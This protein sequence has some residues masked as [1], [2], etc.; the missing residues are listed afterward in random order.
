MVA[1]ALATSIAVL[2]TA[3]GATAAPVAV[4]LYAGSGTVTFPGSTTPVTVW[5]YTTTGAAP[6]APGGP[7][8]T[9]D[10]GDVVTITL[11]NAL[12][13][14]TSLL[15]Q[16][17]G[18]APD[19][20]G[21]AAA[22]TKAYTFTA[23][24]P[25][26]YLYEAGLVP[27]AQYQVAMGLY[28]ALVVRPTTAGQ[29]YDDAATAFDQEQVLVL[30]E[31]D[32]ALN[33]SA[34]RATY[35]LRKYSPRYFLVNG[36]AYPDTTSIPTTAGGKLLLRYVNAGLQYHSM[37]LQGAY[38]TV[39]ALDGSPLDLPRRYA[40]DTF[41]PG[42]TTD[43]LVT[44]STAAPDRRLVLHD[45]SM[46]LHNSNAAGLGGML[47]F[48][49]VAGTGTTGDTA[50]PVASSVALADGTLTATISDAS[51]GGS[52]VTGATAW[53]DSLVGA[54]TPMTAGDAGFDS[55]TEAVT[56]DLTLAPGR[57]VV[58]VRGADS[59]TNAGVLGSVL[60][61]GGDTTGPT[62]TGISL[63]PSA[64]NGSVAVTVSATADDTAAGGH[65]VA[66]EMF[67]DTSGTDGAGTPLAVGSDATISAVSG[68]L[69]AATV[70]A[71][72]EG[73]HSVLVHA[74]D[75]TG[76]WGP[77]AT[78]DL[79]VDKT[80]PSVSGSS[81]SPTPNNGTLSYSSGTPSVRVSSSLA[82]AGSGVVAA[83]VFL[84][85]AGA[86]GTGIAMAAVDGTLSSAS[87]AAYA[88][89]PLATV[90]ALSN[91]SHNVVVHAR[92]AAG[93]WGPASTTTLVVDKV[94]PVLSALGATPNPTAG[95]GTVTLSVT[96]TDT[97]PL[98]RVE[99][100]RGA[101]PG[102]GNATAMTVAGAGPFT[103]TATIDTSTW[104]EG[105]TALVV[106]ARDAAGNWSPTSS[107]N[108]VVTAPVTFSTVGN[109]N[110]PGVAGTADD[111][112]LYGWSGSA[113]SR[114]FDASTHAVP[115]TANVDGLERVDETHAYL[116][117]T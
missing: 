38:Q 69:P 93:T 83:E 41:G 79:V 7:T 107:T 102:A 92:D 20:T 34:A 54:G 58:Y 17:Q 33:N 68:A 97:S 6:T 21:A 74:Q 72:T 14:A 55:A 24:R 1:G 64:T 81:V 82:D 30:S 70:A 114:T 61:D 18:T 53:V 43:V 60:V 111:A 51:T 56:L 63:A 29:A 76:A 31:V 108:L 36:K 98:T 112:D 66:A 105:T 44:P 115:A 49:D 113:F 10:Q 25:G 116:S 42:Q 59:A 106:R 95:A 88:D 32:P 12:P 103:A 16:G 109:T 101:D 86:N 67:V 50:G 71:L 104:P 57:H 91:G 3:T 22:S 110:P 100:Y 90:A 37:E 99:W 77:V 45:G 4:D 19:R 5:G 8:I 94:K 65:V 78:A 27:G 28:G 52:T 80:G 26:T 2:T 75:T 39:I 87:E 46:L 11:H 84:D 85:T 96:V 62:T 9:V 35:D 15:I 117:F 13:A 73:T 23:S 89:I 40:A 47:T 48:V